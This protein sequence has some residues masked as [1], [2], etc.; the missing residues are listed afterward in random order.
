I[1]SPSAALI[2]IVTCCG[3]LLARVV[4]M[5]P[6][7]D[8][9]TRLRKTKTHAIARGIRADPSR[10]V[11]ADGVRASCSWRRYPAMVML[12]AAATMIAV[13]TTACLADAAHSAPLSEP[14]SHS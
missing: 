5:N 8:L 6:E 3:L 12:I 9:A 14:R 2:A 7:T 13:N 10:P 1:V 11:D 4:R